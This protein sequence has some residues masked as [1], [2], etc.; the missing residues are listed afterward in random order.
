M[1]NYKKIYR[2][3]ETQ[4]LMELRLLIEKSKYVS[5]HTGDKAIKLNLASGLFEELAIINDRL[6]LLCSDGYHYNIFIDDIN[7]EDLIDVLMENKNPKT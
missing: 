4:V 6:T 3:L 5:K 2:D 1:K 7:L